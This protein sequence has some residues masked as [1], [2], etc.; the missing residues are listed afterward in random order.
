MKNQIFKYILLI[1]LL[2]SFRIEISSASGGMNGLAFLKLDVDARAAGMAGA[3]TAL[4]NDASAAYWNPAG[5]AAQ[6]HNSLILMHNAWLAD[7]S[8]EFAALHFNYGKHA[9][10]VSANLLTIPGVEIRDEQPSNEPDGKT[11]AIN[12]YGALSYATALGSDLQTGVTFKY[13]YEKYYLE[14]ASGW[15]IDLGLMRRNILPGLDA[16]LTA[17]NL[18]QMTKLQNER[19]QLPMMFRAGAAYHV[20]YLVMENTPLVALDVQYVRDENFYYRLGVEQAIRSFLV[21]RAGMALGAE[22]RWTVGLSVN[23]QSFRFDYAY[24]PYQY[25]LGEGHRLSLGIRF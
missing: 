21:L 25:D 9:F 18:G 14:M 22:T 10:A 11:E 1:I 23:Y 19:T 8:Q 7:I 5:L 4:A 20:P 6:P 17:Q 13:L 3:Y 16:G 12:F 24:A 2:I 15:A